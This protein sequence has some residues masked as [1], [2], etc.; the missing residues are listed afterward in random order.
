MKNLEVIILAAGKGTRMK[1]DKPKVLHTLG[2]KPIIDYVINASILL[3]PKKIHLVVNNEIKVNFKNH[4]N[5]NIVIQK[6]QNGTGDALNS[7]LKSLNKN[8]LSL[9]LYL[10]FPKLKKSP[11][12]KQNF[13]KSKIIKFYNCYN[14]NLP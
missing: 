2:G 7:T 1:S 3:K 10:N 8:S 13:T 4:S 11:P 14:N 12:K 5:I 6:K 9:I